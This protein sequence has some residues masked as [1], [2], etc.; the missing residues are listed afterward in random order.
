VT[1]VA[2][3]GLGAMGRRIA[4][5]LLG[6]GYRVVVW[7]RSA[8]AVGA[9]AD[10]GA[11]PAADPAGAARAGDLVITMVS[12]DAALR[13]VTEGPRGAAA[14][15]GDG[16]LV[17]M[18]TV[19]PAALDRLAAALPAGAALLDA[20]VLG[21]IAEA[22]AGTLRLLVG[23]AE[24]T[25]ARC[26]RPL[27]ALGTVTHL[28]PVGSGT[29]GKLTANAAL[30][31]ILGLL[32]EVLAMARRLGL[33]HD[34]AMRVVEATPLAAQAERR[35][36]A[37]ATGEY[38]VRFA[39]P[40]AV[41]DAD[42]IDRAAAASGADLRLV[43]AARSWLVDALAAG[44]DRDYSAVLEHILTRHA[45]LPPRAGDHAGAAHDDTARR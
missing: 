36:A 1:S 20:P 19:G 11:E 5:R 25:L 24:D 32:G 34:A 4:G 37:L 44:A 22:E 3:I 43:A 38:P 29:A 27:S 21:S 30:F 31:G 10:A 28:G 12:D 15:I 33:P 41:K 23:G 9:L 18:S 14:G 6:Q 2:V 42:L 7:S 13:D 17:Q 8:G 16:V 40:L 39:L 45:A 35:A 26:A